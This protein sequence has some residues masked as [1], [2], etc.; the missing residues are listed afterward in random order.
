MS[1]LNLLFNILLSP[2]SF[3]LFFLV[4]TPFSQ[5]VFVAGSGV[6]IS[7][8]VPWTYLLFCGGLL[9]LGYLLAGLYNIAAPKKMTLLEAMQPKYYWLSLLCWLVTAFTLWTYIKGM[10]GN[11]MGFIFF[12]LLLLSALA[13]VAVNTPSVIREFDA[14]GQALWLNSWLAF[15][16]HACNPLLV[17]LFYMNSGSSAEPSSQSTGISVTVISIY[18]FYAFILA[19]HGLIF[20][21]AGKSLSLP[22]FFGAGQSLVYFLP[23]VGG[24]LLHL[25]FGFSIN[26]KLAEGLVKN[27]TYLCFCLILLLSCSLQ[28]INYGQYLRRAW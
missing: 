22:E 17:L 25:Y 10:E 14:G 6:N 7:R 15:A 12:P 9:L 13:L 11:V 28:L 26:E 18:I 8:L 5:T 23:L 4:V 2:L 21:V 16:F 24:A 1:Y 3:L 20:L 27:T 19:L